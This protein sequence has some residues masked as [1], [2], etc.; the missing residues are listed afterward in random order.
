[1]MSTLA[2]FF[3]LRPVFTTWGLKGVWIAFL[4]SQ[5]WPVFNLIY[6]TY[7]FGSG[8][9]AGFWL[10]ISPLLLPILVNVL[11]ARVLL[12]VAAVVLLQTSKELP[13]N[14][15]FDPLTRV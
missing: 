2:D 8:Q 14:S 4:L 9:T 11:L 13:R 3:A 1:M 12:E 5:A 7:R 6:G 10:S 15:H